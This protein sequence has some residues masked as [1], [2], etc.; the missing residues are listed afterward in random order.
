VAFVIDAFARRI[1]GWRVSSSMQT[2]CVLVALA[3]A[4]Y[5][6]RGERADDR[7]HHS[8][9]G[10]R[11]GPSATASGWPRPAAQ[12]QVRRLWPPHSDSAERPDDLRSLAARHTTGVYPL[13]TNDNCNFRAV[14]FD[15]AEWREDAKGFAKS[16]IDL[17][18]PVAM[19]DQHARCLGA[20]RVEPTDL[21]LVATVDCKYID[22][23]TAT[24]PVPPTAPRG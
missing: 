15:D 2:D 24:V 10:S 11:M 8:D 19:K 7:V 18:V 4:L 6:R 21:R 5:A 22:M 9:R 14:D 20:E 23:G 3:H 13:L 12:D 1:V 17:G 16:C